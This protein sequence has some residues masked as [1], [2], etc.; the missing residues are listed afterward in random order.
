VHPDRF[1]LLVQMVFDSAADLEAALHS[2]E[3]T[4]ARQ[5]SAHFPAFQGTVLHQAAEGEEVF[6]R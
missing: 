6:R 1:S 4:A 2:A 3:R 5:D